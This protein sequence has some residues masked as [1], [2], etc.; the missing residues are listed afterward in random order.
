MASAALLIGSL[1]SMAAQWDGSL[2]ALALAQDVGSLELWLLVLVLYIDWLL[3][4]SLVPFSFWLLLL[5]LVLFI[6]WL[7][8][9]K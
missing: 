9:L 3:L 8:L 5:V 1:W 6:D 2:R 4:S 7:R